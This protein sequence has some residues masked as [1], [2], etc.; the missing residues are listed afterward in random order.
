MRAT[1]SI[2][3]AAMLMIMAFPAASAQS[4]EIGAAGACEDSDGSGG[5][6][7]ARV[8]LD[9]SGPSAT[10]DPPTVTGAV[11]AAVALAT[12][13]SNPPSDNCTRDGENADYIAVT[14]NADGTVVQACY[15][16]DDSGTGVNTAQ[17]CDPNP[18]DDPETTVP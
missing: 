4:A 7:D 9:A 12:G 13:S 15:A 3:A 11:D 6:D 18:D 16:G 5:N 1:L 8:V 14:V 17:T 10:V 2:L